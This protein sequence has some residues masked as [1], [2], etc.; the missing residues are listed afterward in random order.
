MQRFPKIFTLLIV[1]LFLLVSGVDATLDHMT[2]STAQNSFVWYNEKGAVTLAY[3]GDLNLCK[4]YVK[5][6]LPTSGLPRVLILH[7]T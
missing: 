6:P 4:P 7:R 2:G 5:P 1:T 3:N